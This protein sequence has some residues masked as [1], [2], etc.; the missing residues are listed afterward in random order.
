MGLT[1]MMA[2]CSSED[3]LTDVQNSQELGMF[4]G[5]EKVDANFNWGSDSRLAT[6]FGLEI[7]DM[8][9]LAWLKDLDGVLT[10]TGAA[11]QNHPLYAVSEGTLKPKT[12][13]FEGEYFSYAPYDKSVVSIK[14]IN[15][16]IPEVQDMLSS[17]N[18]LAK[19]AIYISPKW[20]TVS[21]NIL[22]DG[23]PGIDKTFQ[24]YPRKFSNAVRLNFDYENNEIDLY[25]EVNDKTVESDPQI[26]DIEVSY[27]DEQGNVAT[28]NKFQYAPTQE[29][30]AQNWEQHM[31]LEQ[32]GN[33]TADQNDVN[34]RAAV[35][36]KVV[37]GI[38][39]VA[40]SA[41]RLE[42]S[43]DYVADREKDGDIFRYNALPALA[44]VGDATKVKIVA[45]TTY[46]KVTIEKAVNEIAYTA[47]EKEDGTTGFYEQPDGITTDEEGV[48]LEEGT[49]FDYTESF[50]Q[51]LGKNGELNTELDFSTVVMNGM[52]VQN[53]EHLL[54]LLRYIRDYKTPG[55]EYEEEGGIELFLDDDDDSADNEFKISKASIELAR[56]INQ[57][58]GATEGTPNVRLTICDEHNNERVVVVGG[59][60]VPSFN[61]VFTNQ[62]PIYL[63]EEDWT[64]GG[65]LARSAEDATKNMGRVTRVINRGTLDINSDMNTVNVRAFEGLENIATATINVNVKMEANINVYNWGTI[66]VIDEAEYWAGNGYEL[67]NEAESLNE[68]GTINNEGVI[69]VT[70]KVGA[71]VATA[72]NV[73]QII[74]YGL[75]NHNSSDDNMNV[76]T[77]ITSNQTAGADFISP[78]AKGK[79][80]FG[81]I[82]LTNKFDNV[83]VS[84]ETE[85]GF[86]KY[87][88]NPAEDSEDAENVY[89]T[90]LN[91]YFKIK[92]NY[93]IVDQNIKFIE[94]EEEIKFLEVAEGEEVVIAAEA[95]DNYYGLTLVGFI[96]AEGAEAN[97]QLQNTVETLGAYITNGTVRVGGVFN[98]ES[99]ATYLGGSAADHKN[100]GKY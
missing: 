26:F 5:I 8:V 20:T 64:W 52:H 51:V 35:A 81:T 98:Y 47:F 25:D 100:I 53:N 77:Y 54:M 17:W 34:P 91:T 56:Y 94:N 14:D 39:N 95:N 1:A 45:N 28:I 12:S 55:G 58:G 67:V 15:F 30:N 70:E 88:W 75:I 59:G 96:L 42:P 49:Y 16:S 33:I 19:N 82:M 27:I 50:V 22:D 66:N 92:Y 48:A 37:E 61:Q 90:P 41:Y 87:A 99:L 44:N 36:L 80:M 69:T 68:F 9:G 76:K 10:Q 40:R 71:R 60:E 3:V 57:I 62:H 11:Y 6:K 65:S 21:N 31:L 89:Q 73:G 93:L 63:S 4:E 38:K 86:I 23:Q 2:A 29:P 7:D 78:F 97:I 18:A 85:E 84:N 74:N 46:G 32:A 83:S 43:E 13:I 79:N 24:I 72:A